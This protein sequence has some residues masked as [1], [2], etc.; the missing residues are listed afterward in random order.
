MSSFKNI[1]NAPVY[2]NNVVDPNNFAFDEKSKYYR[3]TPIFLP[4]AEC[5]EKATISSKSIYYHLTHSNKLRG[6]TQEDGNKTRWFGLYQDIL[7]LYSKT[8]A[9]EKQKQGDGSVENADNSR[10]ISILTGYFNEFSKIDW[11]DSDIND[12][13]K[14]FVNEIKRLSV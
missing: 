14:F 13:R 6:Y 1:Y 10:L 4:I 7:E 8:N 5:A 9:G 11:I 2:E 12:V 3:E